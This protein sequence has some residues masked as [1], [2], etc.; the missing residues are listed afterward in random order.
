MP[1]QHAFGTFAGDRAGS[2]VW[3]SERIARG[4]PELPIRLN[5]SRGV[6][7]TD[8]ADEWRSR[9][10]D[11]FSDHHL[12]VR[13]PAGR[14][15]RSLDARALGRGRLGRRGF[16]DVVPR[17]GRWWWEADGL[18]VPDGGAQPPVQF[19][20]HGDRGAQIYIAGKRS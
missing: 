6:S 17:L 12:N 14:L 11:T 5:V 18:P 20:A 16:P 2:I 4:E 19:P 15:T 13:G 3:F 8:I 9:C 7:A 10:Q 1:E